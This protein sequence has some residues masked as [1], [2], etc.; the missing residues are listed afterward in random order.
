MLLCSAVTKRL[1]RVVLVMRRV[2]IASR[3]STGHRGCVVSLDRLLMLLLLLRLLLLMLLVIDAMSWQI[4]CLILH[5]RGVV[6]LRHGHV[7]GHWVRDG[8]WHGFLLHAI[9][10]NAIPRHGGAVHCAITVAGVGGVAIPDIMGIVRIAIASIA[11]VGP[12]VGILRLRKHI[13]W[14]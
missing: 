13:W 2:S 11:A 10:G 7:M 5:K 8:V 14:Y 9:V 1:N 4:H 12:N 3:I 6:F